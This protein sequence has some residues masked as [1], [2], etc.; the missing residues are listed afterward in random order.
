M[1]IDSHSHYFPLELIKEARKGN[2]FDGLTIIQDRDREMACHR[3]GARYELKREFYDLSAKLAKMDELE[4]TISVLS[5]APTLFMYWTDKTEA[6]AFCRRL[7]DSLAEF[8]AASGGRIVG[9]ATLPLQDPEKAALELRRAVVE[10]GFHGAQIGTA[11]EGIPLDD[12]RF[13]VFFDEVCK[14]GVPVIIHPYAVGKRER[15]EDFQLNNLVGNPMDTCLAAARLIYSGFL[16]KYPEIKI[17]LPHGGGYLPYQIGRMDRGYA[18]RPEKNLCDHAPSE[19]LKRF[20]FD[21]VLFDP[22]P[23]KFLSDLV[24]TER[25]LAGTDLP[26]DVADENIKRN[27]D[28]LKISE[29]GKEQIFYRNAQEL[30]HF[31]SHNPTQ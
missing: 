17:I 18:A 19:Y 2:A 31:D 21:T 10:L 7:N 25:L 8:A 28:A 29:Q 11:V 1:I 27:I 24:G 6:N 16:D 15:L 14:L 23:L 3:Q 5:N 22:Q 13:E 9:L 26:F 12:A 30:F 4:I 20:Y